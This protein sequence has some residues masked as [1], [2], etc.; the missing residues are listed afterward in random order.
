MYSQTG[1]RVHLRRPLMSLQVG[2]TGELFSAS[3]HFT[4]PYP[5]HHRLLLDPRFLLYSLLFIVRL[6]NGHKL[7][8]LQPLE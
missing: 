5:S 4:R 6:E 1:H 8:G 3:V 7:I 2:F